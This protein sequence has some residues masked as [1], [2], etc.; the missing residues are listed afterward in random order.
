M[1]P[2]TEKQDSL[3]RL[4]VRRGKAEPYGRGS[5]WTLKG[6]IDRGLITKH[7]EITFSNRFVQYV[8][9]TEAGRKYVEENDESN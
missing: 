5:N 8:R 2:L 1:R 4:A 6:L 7:F 3:L 9:P